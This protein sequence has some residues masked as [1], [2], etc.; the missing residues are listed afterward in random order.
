MGVRGSSVGR[1]AVP[2]FGSAK[3][4]TALQR[5]GVFVSGVALASQVAFAHPLSVTQIALTLPTDGTFRV[6]MTCDLDALALGA[7]QDSDDAE[8]VAI[9]QGLS[10]DELAERTQH[11]R[12]L[13]VRR[14]RVRF[15]GEAAPF[16]VR[17]PDHGVPPTGPTERPTLLGLTARLTGT[18]PTGARS[19]E[20][21][22]SRSFADVHLEIVDAARGVSV[23]SILEPGAR[24]DPFELAGPVRQVGRGQIAWQYLKLGFVHIVPNGADHTLFVLGLFLLSPRLRPLLWQVTAFTGAHAVTL[25]LGTLNVIVLSRDIVEPLITL[26]IAWVAIENVLTARLR[27]WRAAVVFV[28]GLLHGLG[29]AGVLADLELPDNERMLALITFNVGIELGQL[30]I[31]ALALASLGWFRYRPWYRRRVIVPLS[32]LIA[33]LGLVWT[34]ERMLP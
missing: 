15:D 18:V 21:F 25:V 30:S 8:L 23:R 6:D 33:V 16:E 2:V 12:E 20:F 28:F 34:V 3:V 32:V 10:P 26:S 19:V 29:F 11:L 9:L 13:F 17:F 7:P 22:A 5:L 14:V 1:R 4:V 31:I 27:P 24:S